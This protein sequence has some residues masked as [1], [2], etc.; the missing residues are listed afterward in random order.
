VITATTATTATGDLLP[1]GWRLVLDEAA[2][3]A[4]DGRVII[5]GAP[6]RVLQL[7]AAG[8]RVLDALAGGRPLP[9]SVAE[10]QLARRLVDAGLAHPR[11]P[12]GT[13]PTPDDVAVVIPVRDMTEGL[14]ET[15]AAIG[16]VG[17]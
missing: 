1:A 6:L 14:A 9:D 4:D 16:R 7:S 12:E 10:R 11:P 2:R 15:L 17:G 5:G 13:G 8:V 3:R